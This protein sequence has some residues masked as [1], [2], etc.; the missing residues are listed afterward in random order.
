[1]FYVGTFSKSMLPALRLGFIVAPDWA[2]PPLVAAK[3]CLD[4]HCS[5]PVQNA[6][7]G[8]IAAGHL[9][10]HVRICAVFTSSGVGCCSTRCRKNWAF[11]WNRS[12]RFMA[13]TWP[14]LRV[15]RWISR[16]SRKP[17]LRNE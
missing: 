3:N 1:M 5:T 12:R 13:C 15:V 14:P 8:F 9:T 2:V 7:A 17:W 4:W 6:V 11:G 10:R 16:R